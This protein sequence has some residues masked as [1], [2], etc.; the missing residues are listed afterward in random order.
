MLRNSLWQFVLDIVAAGV[1]VVLFYLLC[2]MM[3]SF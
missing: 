1:M 2:V 3:F